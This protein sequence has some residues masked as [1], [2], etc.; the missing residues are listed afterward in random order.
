MV[1]LP[2]VAID[3]DRAANAEVKVGLHDRDRKT[4]S[5]EVWDDLR[6][7]RAGAH[8]QC[9]AIGIKFDATKRQHVENDAILVNRM[10]A[11]AIPR[12]GDRNPQPVAASSPQELLRLRFRQ[13]WISGH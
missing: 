5:V 8:M 4:A 13:G 10:T 2:A 1:V 12:A 11:H 6:P 7:A 3:A 9:P